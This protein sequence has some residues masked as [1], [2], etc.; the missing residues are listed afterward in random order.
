MKKRD[1]EL[2]S[3]FF[4]L[5]L[6]FLQN[7]ALINYCAIKSIIRELAALSCSTGVINAV[8]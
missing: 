7:S 5:N 3:L 2:L 4:A 1:S 6:A 8:D